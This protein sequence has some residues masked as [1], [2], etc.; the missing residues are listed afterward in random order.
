MAQFYPERTTLQESTEYVIR[1]LGTGAA[2]PTKQEGEGVVVTRTGL[3]AY[4]VQFAENPFQ[5]AAAYAGFINTT[6]LTAVG[7]SVGFGDYDA[8]N[9]RLAFQVGNAS[10]AAADLTSPMRLTLVLLFAR[11]GY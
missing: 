4:L 1:L 8:V 3:G 7:W 11:T 6:A 9:K 5:F 2:N 10:N